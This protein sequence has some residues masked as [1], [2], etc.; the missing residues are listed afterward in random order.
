[1]GRAEHAPYPQNLGATPAIP[2]EHLNQSLTKY[3]DFFGGGRTI[4][5]LWK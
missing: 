3:T 4:V 1:M 5:G 2:G